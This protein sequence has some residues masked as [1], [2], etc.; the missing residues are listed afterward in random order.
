MDKKNYSNVEAEEYLIGTIL[1]FPKAILKVWEI[2]EPSDF[3]HSNLALIYEV[4]I[5]C[6][7][8]NLVIDITT[9]LQKLDLFYPNHKVLSTDLLKYSDLSPSD[10]NILEYA[11]I[12]KD[13]SI[14]RQFSNKIKIYQTWNPQI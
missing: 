8:K 3:Y 9:V 10:A 2:L 14:A 6:L 4:M 1:N 7:A 11:N 13:L 5:H 12:I